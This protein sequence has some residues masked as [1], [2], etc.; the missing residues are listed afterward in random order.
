MKGLYS[1]IK[2]CALNHKLLSEWGN[3]VTATVPWIIQIQQI[4]PLPGDH[5]N[6]VRAEVLPLDNL[7]PLCSDVIKISGV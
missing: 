4:C 2:R 5:S 6:F 3:G 7:S 1:W